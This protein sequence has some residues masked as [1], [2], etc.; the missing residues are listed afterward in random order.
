MEIVV[1]TNSTIG[2]IWMTLGLRNVVLT[3]R[4]KIIVNQILEKFE[5]I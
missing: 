5:I 3:C 2:V 1:V 4:I